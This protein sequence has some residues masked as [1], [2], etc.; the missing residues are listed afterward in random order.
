MIPII[1]AFLL[2]KQLVGHKFGPLNSD[3]TSFGCWTI[4]KL[5]N[6]K[7]YY[8]W[9]GRRRRRGA[10]QWH[11]SVALGRWHAEGSA[12]GEG[13]E[14]DAPGNRGSN[15]FQRWD[16]PMGF[17]GISPWDFMGGK[18]FLGI[19]DEISWD[20]HGFFPQLDEWNI[21]IYGIYS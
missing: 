11:R 9:Q 14:G 12:Q 10:R 6:P 15:G 8:T 5:L 18:L 13:A 16:E 7:K 3:P 17:S 19:F 2:L 1:N 4:L 20:N 21:H